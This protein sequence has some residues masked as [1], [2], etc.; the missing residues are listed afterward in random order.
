[1]GAVILLS[2]HG[3]RVNEP[4]GEKGLL[5]TLHQLHSLGPVCLRSAD[6]DKWAYVK[7]TCD[8]QLQVICGGKTRGI[9]EEKNMLVTLQKR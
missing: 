4:N 3:G 8:L 2:T 7:R 5:G 6:G 9:W 1:M